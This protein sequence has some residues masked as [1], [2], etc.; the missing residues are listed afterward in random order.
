MSGTPFHSTQACASKRPSGLRKPSAVRWPRRCAAGRPKRGGNVAG[1]SPAR[2]SV[3]PRVPRARRSGGAGDRSGQRL[4]RAGPSG[5][6]TRDNEAMSTGEGPSPLAAGAAAPKGSSAVR[7]S[8]ASGRNGV[9]ATRASLWQGPYF[10]NCF[11]NRLARL[12][13]GFSCR[14]W[15]SGATLS[16]ETT[17]VASWRARSVWPQAARS[18]ASCTRARA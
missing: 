6:P 1:R 15:Y 2:G 8:E 9:F 10:A 18:S 17:S 4:G 14:R 11:F 5:S 3:A 16:S 7:P 13:Q 12:T